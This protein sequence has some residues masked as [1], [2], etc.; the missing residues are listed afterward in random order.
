MEKFN[1]EYKKLMAEC[2][3]IDEGWKQIALAGLVII[4]SQIPFAL[5]KYIDSAKKDQPAQSKV[6]VDNTKAN[7]FKKKLVDLGVNVGKENSAIEKWL[8]TVDP[9]LAEN[10][11]AELKSIKPD[12][13]KYLENLNIFDDTTKDATIERAGLIGTELLKGLMQLK[14]ANLMVSHWKFDE[15]NTNAKNLIESTVV[16]VKDGKVNIN[17][18]GSNRL[19]D[20]TQWLTKSDIKKYELIANPYK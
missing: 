5:H 20:I 2:I 19:Y 3:Q 11:L 15:A 18:A 16:N 13:L 4:G 10:I 17:W 7:M 8:A 6:E 9:A 12:Q 14:A 1:R